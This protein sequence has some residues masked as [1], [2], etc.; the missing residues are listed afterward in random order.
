MKRE[1]F[2]LR[3]AVFLLILA[4]LTGLTACKS[5][6]E[7]KSVSVKAPEVSSVY[8]V[9]ASTDVDREVTMS[10]TFDES[11]NPVS[12]LL[13]TTDT[14][15]SQ[16]I[17][18]SADNF[19]TCVKLSS[20]ISGEYPYKTFS[21]QAA[22]KLEELTTYRIKVTKQAKDMAGDSMAADHVSPSGFK[23]AK[24]DVVTT[25]S[26]GLAEKM[27][28]FD[29]DMDA[30]QLTGDLIIS[31]AVDESLVSDYR[32]YWGSGAT[33]KLSGQ[34][35]IATFS[36]NGADKTH[37][38]GENT[39]VPTG[40]THWLVYSV[41]S[42]VETTTA[43]ALDIP[44]G[45]VGMVKDINASG[46]S[47]PGVFTAM[48]GILYFF[49]DKGDGKY[50]L[51]RS[52]GTPSGTFQ[53]N[54]S[55][56]TSNLNTS[57]M[58]ATAVGSTLFFSAA[59]GDSNNTEL[60][61]SDGTDGGTNM[62]LDIDSNGTMGSKPIYLTSMNNQLYFFADDGGTTYNLWK[63][64][65]TLGGTIR[66]NPA[67]SIENADWNTAYLTSSAVFDG[68]LYFRSTQATSDNWELWKSDGTDGGTNQLFDF[69]TDSEGG[70]PSNFTVFANNLFFAATDGNASP[71]HGRELWKTDGTSAETKMVAD[72][73][74]GEYPS[75]PSSFLEYEGYLYF[76]GMTDGYGGKQNLL[77]TDGTSVTMIKET[78]A[79]SCSDGNSKELTLAGGKLFFAAGADTMNTDLWKSD[80]S[81]PGTAK[82]IINS[83]SGS[84]PRLLRAIGQHL[85]FIANDGTHDDELWISNGIAVGTRLLKNIDPSDSGTGGLQFN[86]GEMQVIDGTIYFSANDG[87]YGQELWRYYVK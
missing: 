86:S 21:F 6:D 2:K 7:D 46:D 28:F 55:N 63:S 39:V 72:I 50:N 69:T 36:A 31:K 47:Y 61:K 29:Y 14:T 84:N 59:Q 65:G 62:V 26:P 9:D 60:W 48:D 38:F 71:N 23:T 12:I 75:D 1:Q 66:I 56:P 37:T 81:G 42:G 19:Q 17:Q 79:S 4:L 68:A 41:A 8:P 80:G 11:M 64:N 34:E 33:E 27:S 16:T 15:C 82:I 51:W 85:F 73:N 5:G 13:N 52:D 22:D 24:S 74:T 25:S 3:W 53:V 70:K 18:L 45:V 54:I 40:A 35:A 67:Q 30:D 57:G 43:T 77:R 87:T 78:C 76:F 49:A 32:L 58:Y 83:S 20:N 10:V 44:D